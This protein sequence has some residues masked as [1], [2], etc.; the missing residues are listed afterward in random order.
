MNFLS[1]EHLEFRLMTSEYLGWR[2][3]LFI[4]EQGHGTLTERPIWWSF[5]LTW[6]WI[7]GCKRIPW[8]WFVAFGEFLPCFGRLP[9]SDGM[10][11]PSNPSGM[12]DGVKNWH[13]FHEEPAN[14]S[15][16]LLLWAI[17]DNCGL[18]WNVGPSEVR[19]P[20]ELLRWPL[21]LVIIPLFSSSSSSCYHRYSKPQKGLS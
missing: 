21:F 9:H 17:M 19:E 20:A 14:Q 15:A 5:M 18:L 10:E 12:T 8:Y 11:G 7:Y 4:C 1:P 2:V 13:Y 16:V 3:Q 6:V